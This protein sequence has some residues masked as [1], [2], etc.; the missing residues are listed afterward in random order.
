MGL[1]ARAGFL[2]I[3]FISQTV[4]IGLMTGITEGVIPEEINDV[5]KLDVDILDEFFNVFLCHDYEVVKRSL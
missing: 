2:R 3:V 5:I 1:F 4:K